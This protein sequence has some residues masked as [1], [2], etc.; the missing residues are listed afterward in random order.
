MYYLLS[1][2]AKSPPCFSLINGLHFIQLFQKK[3]YQLYINSYQNS[4]HF[5]S[6]F[7]REDI[8]L[9][10]FAIST[11]NTS[12]S[13]SVFQNCELIMGGLVITAS[14]LNFIVHVQFLKVLY[15]V[16]KDFMRSICHFKNLTFLEHIF[17]AMSDGTHLWLP[18][19]ALTKLRAQEPALRLSG[20]VILTGKSFF[21]FSFPSTSNSFNSFWYTEESLNQ[22]TSRLY[23]NFYI[24]SITLLQYMYVFFL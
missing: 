14:P 23:M 3:K 19:S 15:Y 7:Q 4:N 8:C 11:S 12:S 5:N 20:R 9:F 22:L 21:G 24:C 17:M 18:V 6:L 2:K 10:N 1:G 13:F 16:F